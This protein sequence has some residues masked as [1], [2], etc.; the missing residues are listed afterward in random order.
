MIDDAPIKVAQVITGLGTGGAERMLL[1]L[2]K[3]LDPASFEVRILSLS[4]DKSALEVYRHQDMQVEVVDLKRSGKAAGL[5]K[6]RRFFLEF[7]PSVIHAHMFHALIAAI[8][9][10]RFLPFRPALCFTSHLDPY[11]RA[12]AAVVRGLRPW[13]DVDIVFVEGQHPEINAAET[14]IIPNGVPFG[15]M[16]ERRAWTPSGP[17]K[18][19]AV[20]RVADQK[21]PLGMLNSFKAAALP[22]ATLAFVGDG[23]LLPQARAHTETLGLTEQVEFHGVSSETEQF[24]R[25]ADALV[26]HSKYEGMPMALLEAAALAMPIVSTPVGAATS[27]LGMG[28]GYLAEASQFSQTLH[29]AWAAPEHSI[30]MG[31]QLYCYARE[32]FSLEVTA[33]RHAEIYRRVARM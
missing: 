13:R 19:L 7:Q 8:A 21:D 24:M 6:V 15:A 25:D 5:A 33:S 4:S 20:G 17:F 2:V 12:R 18:L 30:A 23:P 27:V 14:A 28:R 29:R 11:P 16:P 1:N 22:R 31:R 10:S 32:H 9:A 26:M 3:A